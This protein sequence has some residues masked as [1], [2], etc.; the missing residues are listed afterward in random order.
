MISFSF[1]FYINHGTENLNGVAGL[2]LLQI[3][4][5]IDNGVN[6]GTVFSLPEKLIKRILKNKE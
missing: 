5:Q 4:I 2:F 1:N 3:T 6:A